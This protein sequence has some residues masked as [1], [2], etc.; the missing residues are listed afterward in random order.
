MNI[1]FPGL[2]GNKIWT[3]IAKRHNKE[4]GGS[5]VSDLKYKERRRRNK[6]EIEKKKGIQN[7]LT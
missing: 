7:K 2:C 3:L 6:K 5:Q 4:N 1:L